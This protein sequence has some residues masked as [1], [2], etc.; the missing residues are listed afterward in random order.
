MLCVANP[1]I[2]TSY[3]GPLNKYWN[4]QLYQKAFFGSLKVHDEKFYFSP[5]IDPRVIKTL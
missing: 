3:L 4:Q 1:L 5:L 2:N